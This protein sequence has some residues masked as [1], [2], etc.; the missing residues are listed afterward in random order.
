VPAALAWT[1]HYGKLAIPLAGPILASADGAGAYLM[2]WYILDAIAQVGGIVTALVG[3]CTTEQVY[4]HSAPKVS[5][6]PVVSPGFSGL[7]VAGRF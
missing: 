7:A 2:P 4:G 1:A 5:I 6:A 3:I